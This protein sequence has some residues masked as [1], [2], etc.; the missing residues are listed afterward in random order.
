MRPRHQDAVVLL[1]PKELELGA[2]GERLE[3]ERAV[4]LEDVVERAV[5]DLLD[6]A[7]VKNC[8]GCLALLLGA[9]E[10]FHVQVAERASGVAIF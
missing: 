7:T 8:V 9:K 3:V 6:E 10:P 2:L 5:V 4:P 1:E